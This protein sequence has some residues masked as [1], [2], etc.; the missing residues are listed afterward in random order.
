MGFEVLLPSYVILPAATVRQ[1]KM[2]ARLS[3]FLKRT[4]DPLEEKA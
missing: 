4:V 3:S 1:L 2:R